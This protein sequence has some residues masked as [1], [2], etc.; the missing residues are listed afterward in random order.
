MN[1]DIY[2]NILKYINYETNIKYIQKYEN[3]GEQM[4]SIFYKNYY[5]NNLVCKKWNQI[6]NKKI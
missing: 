1:E 6:I 4:Y 3:D 5:P 2:E